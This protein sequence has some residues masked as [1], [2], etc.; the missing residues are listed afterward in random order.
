[1]KRFLSSLAMAAVLLAP[2]VVPAMA[3][4]AT[5]APHTQSH[6]HGVASS[7]SL[8]WGSV[9]PYDAYFWWDINDP[10]PDWMILNTSTTS[11]HITH[12]FYPCVGTNFHQELQV[13]DQ[14]AL[15]F[16]TSTASEAGGNPC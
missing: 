4:S 5:I 14:Q 1:M 2:S 7:W 8:T 15:A 6:A 13:T 10:S 16:D 9:A 11:K 3:T 12:T